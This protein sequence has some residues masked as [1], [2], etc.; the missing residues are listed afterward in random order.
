[1]KNLVPNE[2]G[3]ISFSFSK[4]LWLYLILIPIFFIKWENISLKTSIIGLLLT[5]ITVCLGHSVG[6]HRG[7]IHK[8]YETSTFFKNLLLTCFVFTG[9][10]SPKDWLKMHYYRDYWQNRLDCPK[11]FQ[12]KHSLVTDYFWNLH[13]VFTPKNEERYKIPNEDIQD[14]YINFLDKYWFV[15]NASFFT[16]IGLIFGINSALLIINFRIGLTILGHWF[17]GYISHKYGYANYEIDDADE[18][19]YNNLILGYISFGEG[20]HNNHH[21]FPKSAKLG[22]KW[23]EFDLGWYCI[24]LF[25]KIKW[26]QN[27]SVNTKK[28]TAS[29]IETTWNY[30]FINNKIHQKTGTAS[31][32]KLV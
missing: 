9:L 11:Y 10:G 6:L 32:Q 14:K 31:T 23:Y 3:K 30:P 27:V 1:M 5:F 18:S 15:L 25:K 13:L 16:I 28:E 7:I 8:S 22:L 19:A 17:I 21:A 24:L 12:Y 29:Q 4:T 20:F 26:I 2:I